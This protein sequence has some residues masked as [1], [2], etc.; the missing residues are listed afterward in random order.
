MPVRFG[1]EEIVVLM[2]HSRLANAQALAERLRK[3]VAAFSFLIDGQNL[4]TEAINCTISI[5]ITEM[6]AKTGA[7][8]DLLRLADKA[9]YRAKSRGRNR[10]ESF[11]N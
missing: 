5:G 2:P 10:V 3:R 8:E 11:L 6:T 9:L 1:G 7:A 4:E